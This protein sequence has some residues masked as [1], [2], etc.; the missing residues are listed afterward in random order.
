MWIRNFASGLLGLVLLMSTPV[1]VTAQQLYECNWMVTI[2]KITTTYADAVLAIC[3]LTA[4]CRGA[5]GGEGPATA[6]SSAARGAWEPGQEWRVTREAEIGG[7]SADGPASFARVV[8][9]ALD[10]LGRVWV[11]DAQQHEIRV[12]D[13]DGRHVRSFGRMGGGPAEFM[14][15]AGMDWGPD[16]QLW[17]LDGGNMRFA[18]YDT[19]GRLLATHRRPSSTVVA[20]WPLGFDA[21]NRLYDLGAARSPGEAPRTLLR[22]GTDL[23]PQDSF[24]LPDFETPVLEVVRRQ[25]S[26]TSVEQVTV[27]FAGLQEWRVDPEGF[28]WVGVTDR[29][30]LT[31]YRWDGTVD[32][33]VERK[34]RPERIPQGRRRTIANEY[35]EF[36]RR[37]GRVDASRVPE[38]YP[39]F[40]GFFFGEDGTLW[41]KRTSSGGDTTSTRLDV[42]DRHGAFQGTVSAPRRLLISPAPVVRGGRMVGVVQD[43]DGV[44]SVVVLRLHKPET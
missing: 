43:E 17:V 4:G 31:R 1:T 16:G 23:Q 26:T 33:V 18:V 42:F 2:T 27:P 39:V 29:Y 25:G 24:H 12:F 19:A 9:V 41:V 7:A 36:T 32:R 44:E 8:D 30:R 34:L 15:I 40:D 20:P 10:E 38:F 22:S 35:R 6:G 14:G 21:R 28:V 5:D 13:P 3:V 11:A 37:G